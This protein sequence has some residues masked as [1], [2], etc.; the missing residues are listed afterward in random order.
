MRWL[1]GVTDSMAV[2]LSNLRKMVKD[3]EAWRAAVRGVAES[4]TRL[5][6]SRTTILLNSSVVYVC[7]RDGGTLIRFSRSLLFCFFFSFFAM[8][9]LGCRVGF[10]LVAVHGLLTAV[11]SLVAEHRL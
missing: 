7:Y 2:S 5:R 6:D 3:R 11:A 4:Q 10:S 1:D 8:L 9:G